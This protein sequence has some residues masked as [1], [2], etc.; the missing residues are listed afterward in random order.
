MGDPLRGTLTDA[1]DRC[2]S[3]FGRQ[4]QRL[5]GRRSSGL[6]EDLTEARALLDRVSE[7][8]IERDDLGVRGSNLQIE[9]RAAEGLQPCFGFAH[10]LPAEATAPAAGV[11][12]KVIDPATIAV[13]PGDDGPDDIPLDLAHEKQLALHSELATDHS[14]GPVP[15]RVV[16]EHFAP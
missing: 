13:E 8:L 1:A 9:L 3:A 7:P 14:S 5:V 6:L 4:L 2:A 11:N 12:G 10:Q 16:S 15:G